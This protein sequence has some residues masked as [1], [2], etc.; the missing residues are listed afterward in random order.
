MTDLVST[1]IRRLAAID[2]AFQDEGLAPNPNTTYQDSSARRTLAQE[3]LEN[4]IWSDPD[5]AARARR[6]VA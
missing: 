2:R 3:Y 1:R 5:Q 6:G 4:V